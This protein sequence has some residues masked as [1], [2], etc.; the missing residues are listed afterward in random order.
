[1]P[2][3]YIVVAARALTGRGVHQELFPNAVVGVHDVMI[4]AY[5]GALF[6]DADGN[7][8]GAEIHFATL[9]P[10]TPPASADFV[11]I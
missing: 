9:Q 4:V 10:G 5:T 11:V 2:V 8:A 7:G 1:M 6:F 3:A